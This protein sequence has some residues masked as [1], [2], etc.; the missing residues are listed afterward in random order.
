MKTLK[1]ASLSLLSIF[2][3]IQPVLIATFAMVC[4]DFVTGV[5]AAVHRKEHITS[6]GFKRTVGKIFVFQISIMAAY[7]TE[8]Y[9]TGDMIPVQKMVTCFVGLTELTSIV[10][11]LNELSGGSLLKALVEKISSTGKIH[12]D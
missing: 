7:L 9:F 10:E 1:I 5:A 6:S 2:A 4:A 11:N 3:P 12:H 8:Q